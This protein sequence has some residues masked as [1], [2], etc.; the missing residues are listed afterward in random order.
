MA[1]RHS[2]DDLSLNYTTFN[3]DSHS[4]PIPQF[5]VTDTFPSLPNLRKSANSG[6]KLCDVFISTIEREAAVYLRDILHPAVPSNG[7]KQQ[8]PPAAASDIGVSLTNA[9]WITESNLQEY[10]DRTDLDGKLTAQMGKEEN[11]VYLL[12]LEL[13]F[14]NSP[15]EKP[16]EHRRMGKVWFTVHVDQGWSRK[17]ER[18]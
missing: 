10:S 9:E 1:A 17:T 15:K 3:P 13:E 2:C 11:G 6:C 7:S 12:K 4:I 8:Q 5:A 14:K 18:S 16:W